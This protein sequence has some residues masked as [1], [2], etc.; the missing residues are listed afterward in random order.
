MIKT[1]VS[2]ERG[3]LVQTGIFASKSRIGVVVDVDDLG[4]IVDGAGFISFDLVSR[5]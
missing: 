5:A 2:P 4:E 1:A 3:L